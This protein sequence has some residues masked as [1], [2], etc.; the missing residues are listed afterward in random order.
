MLYIWF[1]YIICLPNLWKLSFFYCKIFAGTHQIE[2]WC[3]NK[4][5]RYKSRVLYFISPF[6]ILLHK[7]CFISRICSMLMAYISFEKEIICRI[8]WCININDIVLTILDC[9]FRKCSRYVKTIHASISLGDQTL[10][11][12]F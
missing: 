7:I 8:I 6:Q 12:L 10:V 11:S 2:V 9:L 5:I 1:M 3:E 4:H